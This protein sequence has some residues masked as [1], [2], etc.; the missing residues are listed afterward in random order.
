MVTPALG[1]SFRISNRVELPFLVQT[2]MLSMDS[3]QCH[4]LSK[5]VGPPLCVVTHHRFIRSIRRD[6]ETGD[7]V[8]GELPPRANTC[9]HL[10]DV[11]WMCLCT[12]TKASDFSTVSTQSGNFNNVRVKFDWSCKLHILRA[13]KLRPLHQ[14]EGYELCNVNC[15]PVYPLS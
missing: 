4:P 13:I 7:L 10:V 9:I 3:S 5:H 6:L 14:G 8:E 15:I 2:E 11:L 12:H 1:K